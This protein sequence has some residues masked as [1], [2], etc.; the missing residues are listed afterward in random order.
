MIDRE[1]VIAAAEC[2]KDLSPSDRC[3][4]CPY[5]YGYLDE[6]GDNNPFWW[7]NIDGIMD[8]AIALL[9]AQEPGVL[10]LEELFILERLVYVDIKG[11]NDRP[12]AALV[13]CWYPDATDIEDDKNDE[14]SEPYIVFVNSDAYTYEFS[15][16]GY[17]VTWRCWD[18]PPSETEMKE[19]P[20]K[21][22]SDK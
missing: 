9:K 2:G 15:L 4:N 14:E 21:E 20:W 7:C 16:N 12:W 10:N 5:G 6:T 1:K 8:D 3:K 18:S 19:T 11:R 22:A 17:G 13:S